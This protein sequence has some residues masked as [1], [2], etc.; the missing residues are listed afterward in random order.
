[1]KY[2]KW[3]LLAVVDVLFNII[4]Y[5]T[6]P[7]VLLFADE[8]GNLPGWAL[9]WANWDDHLDV[10]WMISEHHVPKWAEYDFNK[11]YRYYSEWEALEKTGV[12]RGYVELLDPNFTLKERF[13]RYVCRLAWLYR[14]CA[15]GFSYY[16]TG[17]TVNGADIQERKTYAKDG[18]LFKTAPNAWVIRYNGKSFA[19]GHNW[20]IF[21]GWKMH[22]VQSNEIS[23]CMLAF[24][25][26][27]WK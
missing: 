1:M 27:P 5:I 6:N 15:Y 21:L 20:K 9:W 17:V 23:R 12:F 16:V 14:N 22:S 24:C 10:E 11:H 3:L 7:L 13:Q 2:L 25:V 4:A 8:L 19:K 18:Y 26:N